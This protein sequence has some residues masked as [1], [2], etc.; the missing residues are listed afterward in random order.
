MPPLCDG[1]VLSV[2]RLKKR[3]ERFNV[4][5][6]AESKKAARAARFGLPV[7]TKGKKKISVVFDP[8]LFPILKMSLKGSNLSKKTKHN[9]I[10]L[11]HASVYSTSLYD[12]LL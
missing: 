9:K 12:Q 3:A 6:T 5:G 4:P 11:S 8:T 10:I 2:E 1:F 7:A